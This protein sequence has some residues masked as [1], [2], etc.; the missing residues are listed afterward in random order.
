MILSVLSRVRILF[1]ALALAAIAV[2]ATVQSSGAESP[3]KPPRTLPDLEVRLQPDLQLIGFSLKSYNGCTHNT[4]MYY[5]NVTVKNTSFGTAPAPAGAHIRV[6]DTHF[7]DPYVWSGI[8]DLPSLQPNTS[9]TITVAIPFWAH[10]IYYQY[11]NPHVID[12]RTHTF[13][14]M[15]DFSNLVAEINETNNQS[16]PVTVNRPSGC[17]ANPPF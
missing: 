8:A 15:V 10:E 1:V 13:K 14:A 11:P 2:T 7:S 9:A 17:P 6:W 16:G 4:P 5:F 12:E 3:V